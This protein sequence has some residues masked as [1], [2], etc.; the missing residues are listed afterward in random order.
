MY[1]K[2]IPKNIQE[3][4]KAKERALAW[5]ESGANQSASPEG[6]LK[7][8]DIQSR[9]TFVRMCSNKIDS[10]TAVSDTLK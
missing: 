6:A 4:L 8:A 10:V 3:K 1:S 2:F 7:P 5:K 9:T